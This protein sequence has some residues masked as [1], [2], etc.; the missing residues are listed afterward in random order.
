MEDEPP[1][2]QWTA[3]LRD[4]SWRPELKYQS[5]GYH[6]TDAKLEPTVY[7]CALWDKT[8]RGMNTRLAGKYPK[9]I[10]TA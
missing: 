6:Y 9:D 7:L 1:T 2:P 3:S 5:Q 10:Y 4:L 8:L